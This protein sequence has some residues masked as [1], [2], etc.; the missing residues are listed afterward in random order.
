MSAE[1]HYDSLIAWLLSLSP[2]RIFARFTLIRSLL[3][4]LFVLT[5][6]A[7]FLKKKKTKNKTQHQKHQNTTQKT[8][9]TPPAYNA[10]LKAGIDFL[11]GHCRAL[12]CQI[13]IAEIVKYHIHPTEVAWLLSLLTDTILKHVIK[14]GF[15]YQPQIPDLR[16]PRTQFISGYVTQQITCSKIPAVSI[17]YIHTPPPPLRQT[18][19]YHW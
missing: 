10:T 8:Q 7:P 14:D 19:K 12:I 3:S 15:I 4:I 17:V 16:Y 1:V 9:H 13:N 6:H 2:S 5:H 11:I 18:K